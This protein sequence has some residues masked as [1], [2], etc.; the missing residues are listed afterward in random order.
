MKIFK[1]LLKIAAVL[2]GLFVLLLVFIDDVEPKIIK[3]DIFGRKI[4]FPITITDAVKRY[5]LVYNGFRGISDIN[6]D[7]VLIAD[8]YAPNILSGIFTP[9]GKT[10]QT[11]SEAGVYGMVWY[12]KNVSTTG[13]D[14]LKG[15][16]ELQT[17]KKFIKK[18]FTIPSAGTIPYF[19][20]LRV[21][22]SMSLVLGLNGRE[23][24][25]YYDTSSTKKVSCI[26]GIYY[27]LTDEELFS[28][29]SSGLIYRE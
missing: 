11:Y 27:N 25:G 13:I 4:Q 9:S 28:T 21:N 18:S 2:I 12:F 19:Y 15:S 23:E 8:T 1:I 6:K 5:N 3:V 17:G 10:A 22:D 14:S 24:R 16:L 7:T 20:C 26:V 29:V